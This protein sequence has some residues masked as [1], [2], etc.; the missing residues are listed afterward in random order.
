[1]STRSKLS[2]LSVPAGTDLIDPGSHRIYDF[3]EFPE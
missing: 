2:E 1:M 3:L